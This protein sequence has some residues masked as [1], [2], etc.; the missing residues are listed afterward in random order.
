MRGPALLKGIA[1]CLAVLLL[2]RDRQLYTE[3]EFLRDQLHLCQDDAGRLRRAQVAAMSAEGA[4]SAAQPSPPPPRPAQPAAEEAKPQPA[5]AAGPCDLAAVQ[6]C[7]EVP[8][9]FHDPQPKLLLCQEPGYCRYNASRGEAVPEL[10]LYT[11]RN[12]MTGALLGTEGYTPQRTPFSP[13]KRLQGAEFV[14]HGLTMTG[15]RRMEALHELLHRAYRDRGLEGDFLEAGVWR[16][17]SSIYAK[18]FM[19][20]YGLRRQVYVVDS[21]AG[22]P[23]K[24]H[25]LDVNRWSRHTNYLG[26]PQDQVADNFER[27]QLLDDDVHFVKGWF[28]DSLP[29]LR[30]TLRS[31]AVVRLDGDMYLSTMDILCNV[32]DK[33]AVGGFWV[34][35]DWSI[36]EARTAVQHFMQAHNCTDLGPT[37]I[38]DTCSYFEK[39]KEVQLDHAWCAKA[40]KRSKRCK[41]C[42]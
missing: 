33:I 31:L 21:F 41:G 2:W 1:A 40:A 17:G 28:V 10:Y 32:Y 30:P 16:G 6:R 37:K 22:L 26:V 7:T 9:S 5:A 13:A 12:S 4:T 3:N 25:R 29:K 27:H 38:D 35:D 18:G 15:Q 34:V 8:W 14:V 19:R 42:S 36:R 24:Q 11:L 20:A 39:R 23:K